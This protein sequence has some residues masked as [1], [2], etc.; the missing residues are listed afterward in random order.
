MAVRE[1]HQTVIAQGDPVRVPGQVFEHLFRP[2][3]GLLGRDDPVLLVQ[4]PYRGRPRRR[5][6]QRQGAPSKLELAS[7][8]GG[9]KAARYLPRKTRPST[10]TG[11]NQ[12][13]RQDTQRG[14]WSPE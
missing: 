7:L 10:R 12:L 5:V 13:G 2:A 1:L 8:V 9:A 11:K 6:R 4:R 14:A 3:K